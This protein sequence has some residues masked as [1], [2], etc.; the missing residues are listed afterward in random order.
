LVFCGLF[1]QRNSFP[2][3]LAAVF[4]VFRV[5]EESAAGA[6]AF[7]AAPVLA[8]FSRV[9]VSV[10]DY[11]RDLER[12]GVL[13]VAALVVA[14]VSAVGAVWVLSVVF[15]LPVGTALV[16]VAGCPMQRCVIVRSG[17]SHG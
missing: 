9:Q 3:G 16:V 2:R 14:A 12:V 5:D 17:L 10:V 8:G 11:L 4:V 13:A 1:R 6:Y 7:S 15:G